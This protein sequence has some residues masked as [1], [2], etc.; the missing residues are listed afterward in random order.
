MSAARI[1]ES[2]PASGAEP[3]KVAVVQVE[4]MQ[5]AVSVEVPLL[6]TATA[7]PLPDAVTSVEVPWPGL[8]LEVAVAVDVMVPAEA[9]ALYFFFC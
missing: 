5:E 7:E 4:P 6:A 2:I 1:L 3:G 8:L 9:Y